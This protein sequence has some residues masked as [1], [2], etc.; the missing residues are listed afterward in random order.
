MI[1]AAQLQLHHCQ[2]AACCQQQLF[3]ASLNTDHTHTHTQD[4]A[5]SSLNITAADGLNVQHPLHTFPR[6]VP[7]DA[8]KLPTCFGLATGKLV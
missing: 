4:G 8:W 2:S 3:I 1:A 6:N 7:V 5:Q